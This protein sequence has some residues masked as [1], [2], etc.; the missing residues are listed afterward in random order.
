MRVPSQSP[1]LAFSSSAVHAGERVRV[2]YGA[3]AELLM[4]RSGR[5]PPPSA[6]A[7]ISERRFFACD[8]ILLLRTRCVFAPG[9]KG[10]SAASFAFASS[11]SPLSCVTELSQISE[12]GVANAGAVPGIICQTQNLIQRTDVTSF[13]GYLLVLVLVLRR[14]A[15]TWLL[16]AIA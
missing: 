10:G 15:Y 9:L 11:S 12:L 1:W 13:S 5:F 2:C 14:R 8:C 3:A 6:Q 16:A 7:T 4:S